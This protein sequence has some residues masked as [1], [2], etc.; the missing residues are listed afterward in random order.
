VRIQLDHGDAIVA[1][2]DTIVRQ[3]VFLL[4]QHALSRVDHPDSIEISGSKAGVMYTL[5]VNN[6][7]DALVQT[8]G[9]IPGVSKQGSASGV[10]NSPQGIGLTLAQR[11]LENA[12]GRLYA[13]PTAS[14]RCDAMVHLPLARFTSTQESLA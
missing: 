8:K 2:P 6:A 4:L 1:V 13:G 7:G 5:C 3:C 14:G 12:G 10:A 11:A 9:S